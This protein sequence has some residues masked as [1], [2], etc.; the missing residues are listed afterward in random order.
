MPPRFR[1][2]HNP[3]STGHVIA[4]VRT[5][6]RTDGLDVSLAAIARSCGTSRNFLYAYWKSAATLHQL[7]LT[8]ELAHAFEAAQRTCPSD[9]T[10]PGIIDHLTHVVRI[11]RRHPTTA[12]VARSSPTALTAAHTAI[13]GPLVQVAMERISDLLHP[14]VPRGGIWGDTALNSRTWKILWIARPAA[15][16]P[17]AVGD[18][19]WEDALDGAFTE[20]LRD[21]LSPWPPA[22]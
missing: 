19:H 20:L 8:A 14:L 7:A 4:T 16:C 17:E 18:Q 2:E 1:Y 5:L 13:E 22:Q 11:V 9:G 3:H 6:M 21:L 12:A 15:L 10:T